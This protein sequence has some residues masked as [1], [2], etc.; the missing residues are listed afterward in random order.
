M[1]TVIASI[2]TGVLALLGVIITNVSSNRNIQFEM[3]TQAA[4]TD[5]KIEELT[6]EVRE[7]NNFAKRV[8]VLEE[9]SDNTNRR[10]D[11]LENIINERKF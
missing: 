5:T 4:V 11:D 9:K 7:H 6:R 10:L 1:S 8:P 3:R 2:I